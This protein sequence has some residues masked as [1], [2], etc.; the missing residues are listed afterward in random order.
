[1]KR[2]IGRLYTSYVTYLSNLTLKT[3]TSYGLT[4]G[5]KN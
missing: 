5:R 1:M 2:A 3:P 4:E